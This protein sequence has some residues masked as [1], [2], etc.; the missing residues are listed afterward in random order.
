MVI[1]ALV[2]M[3]WLPSSMRRH[4]CCCQVSV[5]TLVAHCQAGVITLIEMASLPLMRRRL[6][7]HCDHY[8]CPYDYVIITIN[9]AQDLS[10][11]QKNS[12]QNLLYQEM[13]TRS[14]SNLVLPMPINFYSYTYNNIY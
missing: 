1:V 10:R 14:E 5:I 2:M 11:T 8:C 12:N 4:L 7:H 9:D 6:C 13:S 3:A